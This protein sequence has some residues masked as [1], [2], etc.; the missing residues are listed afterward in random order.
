VKRC[1]KIV[2]DTSSEL[3]VRLLHVRASE[4]CVL[5]GY[6]DEGKVVER[7]KRLETFDRANEEEV[8]EMI[9]GRRRREKRGERVT[10]GVVEVETEG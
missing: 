4:C 7:V 6:E 3:R 1:N 5:L 2:N 9:R 10:G 8:E